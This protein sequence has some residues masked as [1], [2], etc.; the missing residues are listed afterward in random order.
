MPGFAASHSICRMNAKRILVAH[1]LICYREAI[2]EALRDMRPGV[3]VFEVEVASL[4]REVR[5]LLPD[6]VVASKVTRLIEGRMP[7]WVELYRDCESL[8][9]VS[10]RGERSTV[11]DMQL[12][13]LVL[14]IDYADH[15]ADIVWVR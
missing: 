15:P 2:A 9:V 14:L 3:E 7:I 6:M 1:E 13:D 10:I 8:S 11:E 12:S 5:L 4:D